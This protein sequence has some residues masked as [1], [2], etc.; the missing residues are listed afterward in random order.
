LE[1]HKQGIGVSAILRHIRS[2]QDK[3]GN[4]YRIGPT[5]VYQIIAEHRKAAKFV[6]SSEMCS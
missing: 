6:N 4:N 1:L 5:S 3:D 2:T